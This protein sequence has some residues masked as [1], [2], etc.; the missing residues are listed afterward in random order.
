MMVLS[1]ILYSLAVMLFFQRFL[2]VISNVPYLKTQ[3]CFLFGMY[4][5]IGMYGSLKFFLKKGRNALND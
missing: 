2:I 4:L 3:L 5:F 1:I